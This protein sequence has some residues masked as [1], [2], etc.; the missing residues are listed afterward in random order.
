MNSTFI[1]IG[2]VIREDLSSRI[3][4]H[5][6]FSKK[7]LGIQGSKEFK[8]D[9]NKIIYSIHVDIDNNT[10]EKLDEDVII[11]EFN[12]CSYVTSKADNRPTYLVGNGLFT[13]KNFL[14]QIKFENFEKKYIINKK[15]KKD[16]ILYEN[17]DIVNSLIYKYRKIISEN[18]GLFENLY[19]FAIENN[20]KD[21]ALIVYC[22]YNG[23]RKLIQEFSDVIDVIDSM[24]LHDSEFNGKYTFKKSFYSMFNF[25]KINS[26]EIIYSEESIPLFDKDDFLS[27]YYAVQI[28]NKTSFYFNKNTI[29]IFPNYENLKMED[30]ERLIFEGKNIF[31]FDLVCS[32]IETFIKNKNERD[33]QKK[34]LIPIKLKFDIIFR[35]DGGQSGYQNMLYLNGI[36]YAQILKIRDIINNEYYPKNK[37]NNKID[38]YSLL[39]N[40]YQDINGESKKYN[41]IIVKSLQNIYQGVFRVPNQAEFCLID[42]IQ[43]KYRINKK[44]KYWNN[45]FKIYKFLKTMEKSDFVSELENNHSYK[46]GVL[47]AKFESTWKKGRENLEKFTNRFTGNIS[48][49]VRTIEDVRS[50]YNQLVERMYRNDIYCGEHNELIELLNMNNPKLDVNKFIF[51]YVTEKNTYRQKN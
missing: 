15:T 21:I 50:Y 18:F 12:V 2:R 13:V 10:I 19:N 41:S 51:G 6:M 44:D 16:K 49:N 28:Y 40:L 20:K 26:D 7:K 38:L 32:E 14:D 29:S 17:V 31:N 22:T 4:Y 9:E 39:L 47:L 23:E 24:F 43:H 34:K 8:Y 45:T 30:I 25:E 27:L 5:P 33:I 48:R 1:N 3:K 11:Q 42:N 35:Y 36:R 37:D 46:L